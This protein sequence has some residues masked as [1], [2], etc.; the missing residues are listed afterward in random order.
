M[1]PSS[2]WPLF[3]PTPEQQ[4]QKEAQRRRWHFVFEV[5]S[6]FVFLGAIA[7]VVALAVRDANTAAAAATNNT[8]E[9]PDGGGNKG[10]KAAEDTSPVLIAIAATAGAATLFVI[11]RDI[12]R[13]THPKDPMV[14]LERQYNKAVHEITGGIEDGPVPPAAVFYH[15]YKG[16][17]PPDITDADRARLVAL[18][19]KK[20]AEFEAA[21]RGGE[22]ALG[23][24]G[25]AGEAVEALQALADGI[26]A[27]LKRI[28]DK[29]TELT[30]KVD[31]EAK[32][33][34]G[35]LSDFLMP[36][37]KI[38]SVEM[39]LRRFTPESFRI[40]REILDASRTGDSPMKGPLWR[41]GVGVL[42]M[43]VYEDFW[44]QLTGA[45]RR[46]VD[47]AEARLVD[48]MEGLSETTPEERTRAPHL[49]IGSKVENM[50]FA[51]LIAAL[52]GAGDAAEDRAMTASPAAVRD[53][54]VALQSR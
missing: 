17:V 43:H 18:R 30:L 24:T 40:L 3:A 49:N 7:A 29:M 28:E 51:Y 8:G 41:P 33:A 47:E 36:T 45:P 1:S 46:E 5:V 2:Q 44:E 11:V 19:Q 35:K 39:P 20:Q 54:Y 34:L 31:D 23:L 9:G 12:W 26:S 6:S 22:D 38:A 14:K 50:V 53:L 15:M 52:G 4:Q 21:R 16:G 32:R 27:D 25:R 42:A 10:R 37:S 48:R 13:L